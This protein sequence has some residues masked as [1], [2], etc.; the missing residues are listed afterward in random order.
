MP[1]NAQTLVAKIQSLPAD[2]VAE[3]EDFIDFITTREQEQAL[4]RAARAASAPAFAQV[5]DNPE[6]DAYDEL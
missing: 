3:V 6:N 5:W 4:V 2:R 1:A